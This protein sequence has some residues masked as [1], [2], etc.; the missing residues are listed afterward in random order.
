[1]FASLRCDH[2]LAPH[3]LVSCCLPN[4]RNANVSSGAV[5]AWGVTLFGSRRTLRLRGQ[6]LLAVIRVLAKDF[7]ASPSLIDPVGLNESVLDFHHLDEV[8]LFAVWSLSRVLPRH[9]APIGEKPLAVVLPL[10]RSACDDFGKKRT[11]LV[12][13][14]CDTP[15]A[16]N[17]GG[18]RTFERRVDGVAGQQRVHIM[19]CQRFFPGPG[20]RFNFFVLPRSHDAHIPNVTSE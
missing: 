14:M 6:L 4:P 19:V 15:T 8:H 9:P 13:P 17:V 7:H 5:E 2:L 10:V 3:S 12:V 1:M 11:K 18:D 16:Q 20:D